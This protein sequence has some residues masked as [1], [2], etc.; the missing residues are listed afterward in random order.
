MHT[1]AR[2]PWQHAFETLILFGVVVTAALA[3]L[4]SAEV[5]PNWIECLSPD[6]IEAAL[7]AGAQETYLNISD[8]V[9]RCVPLPNSQTHLARACSCKSHVE[10]ATSC[11]VLA[12]MGFI[13]ASS[14]PQTNCLI[15]ITYITQDVQSSAYRRHRCVSQPAALAIDLYNI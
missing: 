1:A 3:P 6:D 12:S 9:A 4:A 15:Y 2:E 5:A 14:G 8:S 10:F 13:Y 7:S 11:P